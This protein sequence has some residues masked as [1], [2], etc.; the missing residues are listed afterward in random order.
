VLLVYNATLV[1][2]SA[3]GVRELPYRQFCTGYRKT[4]RRP[5]EMISEIRI[6]RPPGEA[7]QRW[8]K[9]G[10]RAAQACSKVCLAGLGVLGQEGKVT[11]LDLAAG[12]VAATAVRLTSTSA[13]LLGKALDQEQ[14]DLARVAVLK[15]IR[16]IDDQRSTARY[17]EV[18]TQNL[19]GR[20][21]E[22][23]QKS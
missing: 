15:D 10:G 16:P 11:V 14:L 21:L 4:A 1:L 17:R 22:E 23:L 18:V 13:L 8:Y 9:V 20:F 7:Q 6:P 19:V 3:Q 12:S 5:D 2:R